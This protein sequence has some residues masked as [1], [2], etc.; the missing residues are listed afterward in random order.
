MQSFDANMLWDIARA[1]VSESFAA[2]LKDT[3]IGMIR[4]R[5]LKGICEFDLPD[6][7][8]HGS[9]FRHIRQLKAFFN[10]NAEFSSDAVCS[11][12]ARDSFL[13]AEQACSATNMRL[14][15]TLVKHARYNIAPDLNTEI[16]E[17]ERFISVVL[18]NVDDFL[19]KL[20]ELMKI[21][22][23]ATEDRP[24]QKALPFL[25][26]SRKLRTTPLSKPLLLSYL[27]YVGYTKEPRITEV[28]T[29]RIV[30]VPKNY[31]T[32]RTI[33]CEPTATL[34]FQLAF[35]GYL[36]RRLRRFGC[37]LSD[38]TRNQELARI[39]SLDG[40]F[41]TIDLSAASDSLAYETVA[42]LLPKDWMIQLRKLRCNRY[43]GEVGDGE[44]AKFSS[45]GNGVT[46]SLES[47]IFLALV[48]ASGSKAGTVYGDDIIIEPKYTDTLFKLLDFFGFRVNKDKSFC[49]GPFRESCGTD[50]L[51]GELI[52][53]F[54]VRQLP[55]SRSEMCHL[56]NGLYR[57]SLPF[58]D[59]WEI[60]RRLS[61]GLPFVPESEDSGRGIH[62]TF[63]EARKRGLLV[64]S[65]KRF[66]PYVTCCKQLVTYDTVRENCGIRS[67]L[68]WLLFCKRVSLGIT[69][70][71]G[72]V[73]VNEPSSY[74]RW[75]SG[76]ARRKL[77]LTTCVPWSSHTDAVALWS[78]FT[79]ATVAGR[80]QLRPRR[81]APR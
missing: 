37:D 36:K 16:V 10:K 2:P 42:W 67:Y 34:P 72:K 77:K 21:T 19:N 28:D 1:Y 80:R 6:P 26:I 18:G 38:Q 44:Y 56:I 64:Y 46:F 4:S 49:E 29:N 58:G 68:V 48:R 15:N 55:K 43:K 75:S 59:V 5:N 24:R 8:L 30:F 40:S 66:G 76:F 39:G 79:E 65:S 7:A 52:T 35:D 81:K 17:A 20:P 78:A 32:Y 69:R 70:H 53:P 14:R 31:K 3:L 11:S 60:L 51:N 13:A 9:D 45:M 22:G 23:G 27:R 74:T 41:C 71:N 50:W 33:A 62:I 12:T 54:Y 61:V 47:L 63:E 73:V 57:C 25:K